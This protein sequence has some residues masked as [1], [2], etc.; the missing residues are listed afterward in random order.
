MSFRVR[1]LFPSPFVA[2]ALL[3]FCGWANTSTAAV[4]VPYLETFSANGG[5]GFDFDPY[6]DGA[7]ATPTGYGF[8]PIG[9]RLTGSLTNGN[10]SYTMVETVGIP[11]TVGTTVTMSSDFFLTEP[12]LTAQVTTRLG[13][14]MFG[15]NASVAA[16][17]SETYLGYIAD[18]GGFGAPADFAIRRIIGTGGPNPA[19]ASFSPGFTTIA[20]AFTAAAGY[21]MSVDATILASSLQIDYRIRDLTPGGLTE[22]GT[23]SIPF[24]TAPTGNFFGIH[25]DR[26]NAGPA[27]TI[28]FDNV[29]ISAVPEP[30]SFLML[31]AG[32]GV[33]FLVKRRRTRSL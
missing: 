10:F 22:V 24:T 23:T 26:N 20:G 19:A 13:F 33:F 9:G 8:A 7:P 2:T 17:G 29:R 15:T 21:N 30:S 18:P 12:D 1:F 14:V 32:A 5:A 3:V 11:K 27:S 28:A 6:V 4:T 25:V 16:A 31:G